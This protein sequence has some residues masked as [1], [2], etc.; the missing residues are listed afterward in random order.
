[1]DR[2]MT[3]TTDIT[4]AAETPHFR[5][6]EQFYLRQCQPFDRRQ[7][8]PFE[9][10]TMTPISAVAAAAGVLFLIIAAPCILSTPAPTDATW[11][12]APGSS[13]PQHSSTAKETSSTTAQNPAAGDQNSFTA[14][15]ISP[16]AAQHAAPSLVSAS[17]TARAGEAST[18]SC[19]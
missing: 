17:S 5:Q 10:F 14:A 15:Q 19:A 18:K 8:Q 6:C 9:L 16:I 4:S 11:R 2:A 12:A 13:V 3:N 7:C 1:M